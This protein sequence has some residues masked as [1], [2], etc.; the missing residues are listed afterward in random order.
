[1]S[2]TR[3]IYY[4]HTLF[5][6]DMADARCRNKYKWLRQQRLTHGVEQFW[7]L[8]RVVNCRNNACWFYI[9]LV[10][11]YWLFYNVA[12]LH[13][14]LLMTDNF[15]HFR[16]NARTQQ[17]FSKSVIEVGLEMNWKLCGVFSSQTDNIIKICSS[18]GW[19]IEDTI[20]HKIRA[21]R[22]ICMKHTRCIGCASWSLATNYVGDLI[23]FCY[24]L[25]ISLPP[26][27][28]VEQNLFAVY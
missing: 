25:A 3:V 17:C 16:A 22:A 1:M 10:Y 13:C 11:D 15:S 23:E 12:G 5:T 7:K 24:G 26:A 21:R 2:N 6:D 20:V 8:C 18:P 9:A 14:M 27:T 19:Y 4:S 28:R